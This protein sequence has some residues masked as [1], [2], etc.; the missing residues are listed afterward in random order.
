MENLNQTFVIAS[1]LLLA[2]VLLPARLVAI[3]F[4][5]DPVLK[6]YKP[7][8]P[9]FMAYMKFRANS[10]RFNISLIGSVLVTLLL[11]IYVI[12]EAAILARSNT[13]SARQTLI[14]APIASIFLFIMAIVVIYNLLI[15]KS[16]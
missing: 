9:E 4:N 2:S 14:F 12:H 6:R 13:A 16:S 5:R 3:K 7:D 15:K 1:A 8:S 11:A 10:R